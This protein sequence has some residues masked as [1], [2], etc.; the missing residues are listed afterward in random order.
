MTAPPAAPPAALL[1][2]PPASLHVFAPAG[3]ELRSAALKLAQQRLGALGFAVTLD[4]SEIGRASC[5]ERV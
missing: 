3:V 5:R 2:A 1:A 4:A